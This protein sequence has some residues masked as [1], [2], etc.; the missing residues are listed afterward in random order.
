VFYERCGVS[1]SFFQIHIT[2]RSGDKIRVVRTVARPRIP[3]KM[4]RK[5]AVKKLSMNER[6]V[7]M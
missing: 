4:I 1:V 3:A 7:A 5:K 6:G 2:R